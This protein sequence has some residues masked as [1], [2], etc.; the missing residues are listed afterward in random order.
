MVQRTKATAGCTIYGCWIINLFRLSCLA[1]SAGKAMTSAA[2]AARVSRPTRLRSLHPARLIRALSVRT[3]IL[4]IALIPVVGFAANGISFM[5]GEREVADTFDQYRRA[6]AT[7][8]ASHILKEAIGQMRIAARD[9]AA[10]PDDETVRAFEAANV[11]AFDKLAFIERTLDENERTRIAWIPGRLKEI[12]RRFA[13][14]A[15]DQ[16]K[17]GFSENDGLR[18]QLYDSGVAIERV[19]NQGIAGLGDNESRKLLLSL[20]MMRR[21]EAEQ[22]VKSTN[23][24]YALFFSEYENFTNTMKGVAATPEQRADIESR[25]KAFADTFAAWAAISDRVRAHLKVIDLDT[26]QLAPAAD[27]I[28]QTAIEGASRAAAQLSASQNRTR[29]I[30]LSVG[31]AAVGL[32]LALSLL[33]G[34]SITRPLQ[35]LAAAMARLAKG[36]TAAVIPG[37]GARDEIGNMARTVIVFRNTMLERERLAEAQNETAKAREQRNQTIAGTIAN[38]ERSV[39]DMLGRVRGAAQRLESASSRLNASADDMSAEACAAESRVLEASGNV[40]TAAGS[41]EE[42]AASI[43]EIASQAQK[44]TQVAERAVAEARRTSATMAE[45]ANAATRIG[46]VI[47]LIQSIAGQTNLLALNA[48][49][50]AARAGDAGR[51]FAV[52]ASEVKS[53]AG[54]TARATEEIAGQIGSIQSAAADAAQAIA[55]VNRIIEDMSAIAVN[56]ATT[57]EQQNSAVS[58]IAE[59]VSNASDAA[60]TGADAMS[61]VSSATTEA[62][63]TAADVKA[64]ADALAIEAEGLDSQVRQFLIKVQAA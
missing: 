47:N 13:D 52:V 5:S 21:F 59:G 63:A 45:L 61:R 39:D 57:V 60:R 15:V 17:L 43:G 29:T 16:R 25:V 42:L 34:W 54:Q 3:R 40:T 22:R 44:S 37:T 49:I 32:G 46:E 48:T 24:S 9:F 38:F 30:I 33:I 35:S 51:G 20:L 27:D 55:Q 1:Q 23:T 64:L 56:V 36:D 4:L 8:D 6:D 41:V 28:I 62:R 11:I 53:L 58:I 31:I 18:G 10:N 12:G 2:P 19:I 50:E 7:A 14:V 26:Q